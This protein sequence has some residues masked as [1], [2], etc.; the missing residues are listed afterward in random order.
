MSNVFR[1]IRKKLASENNFQS[2]LRYAI[3]EVVLVVVGILI[4]L[5][6][7]NWNDH[8]KDV[9][10]E[11]ELLLSLRSNLMINTDILKTDM[12]QY[13]SYSNDCDSILKAI[14][15]KNLEM[16][17]L[18][19]YFHYARLPFNIKLSY[20]GYESLKSIGFDIIYNNTL[21]NEIINLFEFTYSETTDKL[22]TAFSNNAPFIET[23]FTSNFENTLSGITEN[24]NNLN[25]VIND[26][27]FKNIISLKKNLFGWSSYLAN[28]CNKENVRVIQLI[29]DE[30]N[31]M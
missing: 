14:K 6:I 29:N 10:K 7:N 2:Y 23:Y 27:L 12:K 8:R 5:S 30:L 13:Q 15:F 24:P 22:N 17:S 21:R 18:P 28:S 11:K 3:G 19:Y 20:A 31:K 4:A 26:P 9:V 16:D 25:K 1:N